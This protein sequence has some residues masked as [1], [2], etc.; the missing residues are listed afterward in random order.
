M[1][2]MGLWSE[3]SSFKHLIG[4]E[5]QLSRLVDGGSSRFGVLTSSVFIV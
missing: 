4:D 1:N 3:A 5:E 2:G